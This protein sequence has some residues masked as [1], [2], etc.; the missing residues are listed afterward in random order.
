MRCLLREAGVSA[1]PQ[2]APSRAQNARTLQAKTAEVRRQRK[3]AGLCVFCGGP[4]PKAAQKRMKLQERIAK[5][6]ALLKNLGVAVPATVAAARP[7]HSDTD[8]V[9]IGRL[10]REGR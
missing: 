7:V 3:A 2:P 4:H 6:Q 5:L 1:K 8:D 10:A 9:P